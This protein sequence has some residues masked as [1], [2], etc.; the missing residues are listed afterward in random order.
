MTILDNNYFP[1]K[2]GRVIPV[3][4]VAKVAIPTQKYS[5]CTEKDKEITELKREI[6]MLQDL[7]RN[8]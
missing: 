4:A 7:L 3:Q 1:L 6:R 5:C 8:K 2:L